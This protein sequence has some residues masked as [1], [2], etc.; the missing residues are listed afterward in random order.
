M[1]GNVIQ[2][3]CM[4]RYFSSPVTM[5]KLAHLYVTLMAAI[6]SAVMLQ[7]H[8]DGLVLTAS[9]AIRSDMLHDTGMLHRQLPSSAP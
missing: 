1:T 7:V 6:F 5:F 4:M 9:V 8:F 2:Q 3:S